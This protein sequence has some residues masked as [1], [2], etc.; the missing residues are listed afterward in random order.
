MKIQIT[1]TVET[2]SR[3]SQLSTM[4]TDLKDVVALY[5]NKTNAEVDSVV[6][7]DNKIVGSSY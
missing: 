6:M 5:T 4:V 7:Y 1:L 3:P 2:E